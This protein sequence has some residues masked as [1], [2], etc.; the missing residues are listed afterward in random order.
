MGQDHHCPVKEQK[1]R[2]KHPK[3]HGQVKEVHEECR[4]AARS[5]RDLVVVLDERGSHNEAD[6]G[7]QQGQGR[8]DNGHVAH[9]SSTVACHG[10]PDKPL[11]DEANDQARQRDPHAHVGDYL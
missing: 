4:G 5:E 7:D 8:V 3:E 6:V 11:D 10:L 9:E 1:P 2:H